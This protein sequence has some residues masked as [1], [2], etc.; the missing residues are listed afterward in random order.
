MSIFWLIVIGILTLVV[1]GGLAVYFG[2][3]SYVRRSQESV[4]ETMGDISEEIDSY[5]TK[6]Q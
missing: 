1:L 3:R 4:K 2:V 5:Q 6:T